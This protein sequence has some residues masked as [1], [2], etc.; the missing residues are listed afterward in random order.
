[1]SHPIGIVLLFSIWSPLSLLILFGYTG[2]NKDSAEVVEGGG[3]RP[4]KA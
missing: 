4:C 2:I 1:M 3:V